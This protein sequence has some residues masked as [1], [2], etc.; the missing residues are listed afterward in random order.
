MNWDKPFWK[1]LLRESDGTPSSSRV[2]TFAT[3]LTALGWITFLVIKTAA[4]PA[5]G[6]V[7]TFVAEVSLGLYGINQAAAL[8]KNILGALGKSQDNTPSGQGN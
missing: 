4:I 7:G 6:P 2:L 3:V 5:I 1:G 8:G